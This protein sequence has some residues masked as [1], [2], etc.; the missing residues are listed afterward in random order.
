MSVAIV[1]LWRQLGYDTLHLLSGIQ[2]IPPEIV[3]V[4]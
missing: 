2:S 4:R 3:S 1:T